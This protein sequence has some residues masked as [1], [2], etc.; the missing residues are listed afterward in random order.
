MAPHTVSVD[1]AF[2]RFGASIAGQQ[3]PLSAIAQ[4]GSLVLLCQSSGFSRPDSGV[5]RYSGKLSESIARA[6]QVEALR[7]SLDAANAARTPVRLII[8][9][10]GVGTASARIHMRADLVGSV[11]EF[12]GDAYSVDFVRLQEEESEPPPQRRRRR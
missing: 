10:P 11:A 7:L 4:D 8:R 6:A 5:L 1:V 2:S 9:T 3:R 12:D